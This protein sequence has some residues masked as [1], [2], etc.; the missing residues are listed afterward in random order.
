MFVFYPIDAV[1]VVD[2]SMWGLGNLKWG[3]EDAFIA[4]ALFEGH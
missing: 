2:A 4:G 3:F 1:R